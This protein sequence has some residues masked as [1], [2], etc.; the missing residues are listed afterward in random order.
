MIRQPMGASDFSVTGN[1]SYDDV[2]SGMSDPDLS[3]FTIAHDEAYIIPLLLRAQ[4]LNPQLAIAA[5]P[6]SPPAWMKTTDSMIGGSLRA[7][8]RQPLADYFVRFVKAY[9]EAGVEIDYLTPQNEPLFQPGGYPGMLMVAEDQRDWLRDNLGPALAT[10]GIDTRVL[11]YDNN[12]DVPSYPET[13]Y[14]DPAAA[15]RVAGTAWHCY[16][17]EVGAQGAVHNSYPNE[18]AHHTECSGG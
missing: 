5:S 4:E 2:P 1:Y 18:E 7:D 14:A 10:A 13:V 11:A 6:W 9:E 15:A 12:W 8:A 17:G 3:E 16:G